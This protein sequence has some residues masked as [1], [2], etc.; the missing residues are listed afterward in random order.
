M[1]TKA[2]TKPSHMTDAFVID[3]KFLRMQCLHPTINTSSHSKPRPSKDVVL[4]KNHE[5]RLT[6]YVILGMQQNKEQ[7]PSAGQ[8]TASD[9]LNLVS[10]FSGS[11]ARFYI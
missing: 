7:W 9:N 5:Q 4:R 2:F 8:C 10:E 1:H 6:A 11:H 3:I